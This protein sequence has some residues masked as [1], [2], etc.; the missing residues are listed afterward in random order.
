MRKKRNKEYDL[1]KPPYRFYN[2]LNTVGIF[3]LWTTI[4]FLIALLYTSMGAMNVGLYLLALILA[5]LISSPLT[6]LVIYFFYKIYVSSIAAAFTQ[7]IVSDKY[8]DLDVS[9]PMDDDKEDLGSDQDRVKLL[10]EEDH[11]GGEEDRP[12]SKEVH[13]VDIE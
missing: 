10:S 5:G 13:L 4:S 2:F 1:L 8:K 11:E 3:I 7:E 9:V 6:M 12:E